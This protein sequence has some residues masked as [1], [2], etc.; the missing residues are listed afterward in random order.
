MFPFQSVRL[1]RPISRMFCSPT[2]EPLVIA[3]DAPMLATSFTTKYET[4][5]AASSS[6][7]TTQLRT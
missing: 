4:P 2:D 6:A 3:C 7:E 5:L 1:S